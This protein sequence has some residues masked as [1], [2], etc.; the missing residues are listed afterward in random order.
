MCDKIKF[1]AL[2]QK[3]GEKGEKT[4]WTYIEVSGDIAAKLK[5]GNKK[6]FRVKGKLDDYA[7][8]AISLTPVGEGDFI[9]A[10]NATIRKG[11]GKKKGATVQVQLEEDTKEPPLSSDF[12]S[13]LEDAPSASV[14]FHSLPKSHQRYF[15]TWIT[16]AKTL[17]TKT[18]R[19]A[20]A[21]NALEI[22]LGFSEMMRMLKK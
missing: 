20:Q 19:I 16:S 9:M 17:P 11:I 7:F 22:G 15:S 21:I 4:G 8:E 14:F 13:C 5:P 1:E 3:F 2:I 10:L 12:L 6:A 18:K